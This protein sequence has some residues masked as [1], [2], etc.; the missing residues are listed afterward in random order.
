MAARPT[1]RGHLK[2]SLVTVPIRVFPATDHASSIS[3]NQLHSTCQT[4]I[5]QKKWCPQCDCQVDCE[6]HSAA[7]RGRSV[8]L[9]GAGGWWPDPQLD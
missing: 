4:R 6:H 1:W 8:T 3:F 2:V 9:V 5:Q 7:C